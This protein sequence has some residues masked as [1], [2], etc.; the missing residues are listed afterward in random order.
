MLKPWVKSEPHIALLEQY[1][2]VNE[3]R[4][5]ARAYW[6]MAVDLAS[7]GAHG[8]V[9]RLLVRDLIDLLLLFLYA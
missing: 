1:V 3:K 4:S 5:L 9:V 7:T 2:D 8:K 6:W